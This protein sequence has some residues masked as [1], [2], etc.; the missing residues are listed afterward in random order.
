MNNLMVKP[1]SS[2]IG[3]NRIRKLACFW[4]YW[5]KKN[6]NTNKKPNYEN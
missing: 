3:L 1:V 6:N 4:F 5:D 2:A